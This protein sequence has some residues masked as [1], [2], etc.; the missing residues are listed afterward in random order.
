MF[1]NEICSYSGEPQMTNGN[2]NCT[3]AKGYKTKEKPEEK[4]LNQT[5]QCNYRQKKRF[6][7]FFLSLFIP[8]GFDYLYL[9]RYWVF[10]VVLV[11]ILIILT[12]SIIC[13]IYVNNFQTEADTLSTTNVK[14]RERWDS[15]RDS[16]KLASSN[17]I[18]MKEDNDDRER[19]S[20]IYQTVNFIL[21]GILII[22]WI[23][24]AIFM[25]LGN[26]T[27]ANGFETENDLEFLFR[28]KSK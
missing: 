8:F 22:A 2:I 3:C 7:A 6:V 21:I 18:S 23:I 20:Q 13:Y 12:N 1:Q 14:H 24:N 15:Q 17:I 19:C 10:A 16:E 4:F 11:I 26:I 5:I 28:V 27:D 9:G 25:G